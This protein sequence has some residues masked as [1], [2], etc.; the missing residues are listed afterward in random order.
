[1]RK[2]LWIILAI[3]F[4]VLGAPNARADSY[5]ATFTGFLSPGALDVT[6]PAPTLTIDY[7]WIFI[8]PANRPFIITLPAIDSPGDTYTW[9]IGIHPLPDPPCEVCFE[10]FDSTTNER[11]GDDF[12]NNNGPIFITGIGPLVFTPVATP[13]PSSIAMLLFG[14]GIILLVARKRCRTALELQRVAHR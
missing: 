10:I 5:T 3:S 13:E 1:M 7:D 8:P 9:Q 2:S 12:G 14:A 11:S 6:F 4:L